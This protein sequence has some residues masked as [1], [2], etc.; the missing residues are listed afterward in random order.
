MAVADW[1]Q[2]GLLSGTVQ[3]RALDAAGG[4]EMWQLAEEAWTAYTTTRATDG[5]SSSS[6]AADASTRRLARGNAVWLTREDVS[7]PFFLIGQYAA[8]AVTITI[9]EGNGTSLTPT[10]VTNPTMEPMAINGLEWNGTPN[11][12]D[13]ILIP[14]ED[15][16]PTILTWNG[17]NWG[18][19]GLEE[20]QKNNG[21]TGV[22][23]VRKTD[24]VVLPGCG[25]WYYRKANGGLSVT[26]PAMPCP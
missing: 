9:A 23:V 20:Y 2:K 18:A 7:K 5:G 11:T 4:Y 1:V 3:I 13:Q 15:V 10:M 24:H 22:R 17:S 14:T 25:F 26:F 19:S 8:S 21:R 16:V 6:E 12:G